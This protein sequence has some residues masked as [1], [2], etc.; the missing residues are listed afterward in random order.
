MLK[1]TNTCTNIEIMSI[2]TYIYCNIEYK[3]TKKKVSRN[4]NLSRYG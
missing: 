2:L 4:L 3:L 1:V